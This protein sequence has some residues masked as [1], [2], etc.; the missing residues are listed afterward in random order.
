MCWI[1]TL[2]LVECKVIFVHT[3]LFRFA[4]LLQYYK[5]RGVLNLIKT[6]CPPL[7]EKVFYNT[8][9]PQ[10][11]PWVEKI[12][13]RRER[14]PTQVFLPREFHGHSSLAGY[15]PWGNKESDA[16]E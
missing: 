9:L 6:K 5:L 3:I 14:Q 7:L 16:T 12:P 8:S 15:S 13:W 2:L 1:L 10:V 4:G 11:D